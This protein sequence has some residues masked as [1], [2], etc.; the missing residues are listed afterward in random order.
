MLN[1]VI[2]VNKEKG[3]T[4]H[5]AVAK[6]R[7]ILKQKKIGHTG[8]LDPQAEGV[9]PVCLGNATKLCD[10]LTDKKKEYVAELLLGVVTDTQDTTGTVLKEMPVNLKEDQVRR[11]IASF[12]GKSMQIPPMYS[13]LKVKGKKLYE[14]AREG[15]VIEREPRPIE[16]SELEILSVN[17]PKVRIRVLCSK[18]TYIRT[19]CADIGEKLGC[20]G[21]MESLLRTR[22]EHFALEDAHTLSQIEKIRDEGKLDSLIIPVDEIFS[23]L[24]KVHIMPEYAMFVENGNTCS[25]SLLQEIPEAEDGERFLMYH[26]NGKFYGIYEY[27]GQE[28][29]LKPYKMFIPL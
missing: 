26:S 19:L 1:G 23:D 16:I 13:A 20:G 15:K 28:E 2:I 5:D 3:F 25:M 6:L 10:I 22:V 18:G 21:C 27:A 11:A 8:T 24:K 7:G 14:L 12:E 4:S 29:M 9:L 17:L